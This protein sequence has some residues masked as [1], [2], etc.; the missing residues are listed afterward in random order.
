[1]KTKNGEEDEPQGFK[2]SDRRS[3]DAQGE[4]RQDAQP[5]ESPGAMEPPKPSAFNERHEAP[6]DFSSFVMSMATS[7]LVAL[8]EYP[9]PETGRPSIHLEAARQTIDILAMLVEKTKGNLTEEED[10]LLQ[11]V[12]YELRM[13]FVAKKRSAGS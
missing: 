2:V 3:F 12:L 8:G 6:I 10:Q 11:G 4:R 9:D 7:V 13:D 5:K 1:M